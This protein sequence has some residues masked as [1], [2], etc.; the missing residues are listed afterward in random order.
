MLYT[1][2]NPSYYHS[3]TLIVFDEV[4]MDLLNKYIV[5]EHNIS[6]HLKR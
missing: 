1:F 2:E 4:E 3:F 6:N 5:L